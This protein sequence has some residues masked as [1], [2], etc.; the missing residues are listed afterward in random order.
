M[1]DNSENKIIRRS[2]LGLLSQSTLLFL[3]QS[4]PQSVFAFSAP[5]VRRA[6]HVGYALW[7]WGLAT[8]GRLGD[9]TLTKKSSPVQIGSRLDWVSISAGAD[10]SV[11]VKSDNSI[12]GYGSN[13]DGQLGTGDTTSTSSPVRFGA[14]SAWAQV[15]AGSAHV[16][17]LRSD[18]TLW[19]TGKNSSGQLGDGTLTSQSSPVRIGGNS[20]WL[21]VSAGATH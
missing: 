6:K 14:Q 12:W 5:R 21:M 11:G 9:G 18:A 2:F 17:A 20:D 1:N 13:A 10:F 7:T 15:S 4:L 8:S 3:S 19:A 16:L